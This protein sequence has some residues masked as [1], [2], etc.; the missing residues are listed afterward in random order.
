MTA[1]ESD[2]YWVDVVD[3]MAIEEGIPLPVEVGK[4]R[5]AF[6]RIND[7]AFATDE[8]CSHENASLADGYL[9]GDCIECPL[10]QSRFD[11]RTGRALSAPATE[12]IATYAVKIDGERVFLN[13]KPRP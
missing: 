11:I 4:R 8:F 10:H 1:E 3:L 5:I 6:F 2:G 12:D 7:E 13:P 9:D